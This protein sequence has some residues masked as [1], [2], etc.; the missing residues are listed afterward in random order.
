VAVVPLLVGHAQ[1]GAASGSQIGRYQTV[2][3]AGSGDE[4]AQAFRIDTVTGK[5]WIKVFDM[6]AENKRIMFAVVP[7]VKPK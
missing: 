7:D 2:T 4:S 6:Q 5:T 1:N 3:V